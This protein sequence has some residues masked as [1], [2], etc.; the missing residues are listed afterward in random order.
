MRQA[1]VNAYVESLRVVWIVMCIFAGVIFVA[2]L[3]WIGEISLTRE[4]ETE[5]GFRY[6]G[7][8]GTDEEQQRPGSKVLKIEAGKEA[9]SDAKAV[10][11]DDEKEV[12]S[13]SIE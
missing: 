13:V 3:V 12:G 10:S 1:V 8:R 2:S 6:D 5:Q 11:T 9:T 4:L 7:K